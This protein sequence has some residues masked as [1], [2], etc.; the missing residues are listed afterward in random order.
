MRY[1]GT[2][3]SDRGPN[4]FGRSG[5]YLHTPKTILKPAERCSMKYQSLHDIALGKC[6]D[7]I[8]SSTYLRTHHRLVGVV[9]PLMVLRMTVVSLCKH[10]NTLMTT[11]QEL[12]SGS[13][14]PHSF[15]C[16][17]QW[18]IS[19]SIINASAKIR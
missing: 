7:P 6:P 17:D 2:V 13:S 10:V 8:L 5:P 1:E 12:A 18:Q 4:T 11:H 16:K 14:S 9:F 19:P 3:P 15:A